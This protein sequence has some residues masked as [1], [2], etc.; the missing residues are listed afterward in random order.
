MG[1]KQRVQRA[2]IKDGFVLNVVISLKSLKKK[3]EGKKENS[4]NFS[5]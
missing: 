5:I 1:K 2:L 3:K 4:L